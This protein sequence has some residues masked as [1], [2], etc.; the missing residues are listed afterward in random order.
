[1]FGKVFSSL[2]TGS[3]FGAGPVVF[4]VWAY[5]ISCCDAQGVVELNPKLLAA[6]LGCDI[7]DIVTAITY[8]CSPDKQSR[9]DTEDGK[10]L[11]KI[12]SFAYYLVNY[13]HYRAVKDEEDRKEQVRTAV[14][15][16]TALVKEGTN[17]TKP[18]LITELSPANQTKP[19]QKTEAEELTNPPTPLDFIEAWNGCPSLPPVRS[20]VGGRL[21]KFK[22]RM[23]EPDFR[24]NWKLI[25]EKLSRSPW[26]TGHNDRSW[27]A[28]VDWILRDDV[29]YVKILERQE[30][31][32]ADLS[33][34]GE[35]NVFEATHD[36][37]A[38]DRYEDWKFH[39]R[40]YKLLGL[41]DIAKDFTGDGKEPPADLVAAIE[42]A[43]AAG[44]QATRDG[45]YVDYPRPEGPLLES[46][47]PP[48]DN[49][50]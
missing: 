31:P 25:I 44:V 14:A 6:I 23:T 1:M 28:T 26:H 29:N 38:Q 15:K 21:K 13:K 37:T 34:L 39:R 24:D 8:L 42:A 35:P 3:M 30:S 11:V 22:K 27:R 17:Q 12:G 50:F 7:E 32:S 48:E 20:I 45:A 43:E 40:R 2:W 41:I 10:R 36:M 9:T 4:A 16:H 47:E 18:E 33:D 46:G 5:A 19:M 49:P